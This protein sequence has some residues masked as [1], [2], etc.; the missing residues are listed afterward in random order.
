MLARAGVHGRVAVRRV[1]A[2]TGRA[3]LLASP[4]MDPPRPDL[5]TFIALPALSL[6]DGRNSLDM[7]AGSFCHPFLLAVEHPMHEGNCDRALAH[8]G[9][10]ALDIACPDV[11][12]REYSWQT[13]F[14]KMGRSGNRPMSAGQIPLGQVRP[15]LNES[16]RIKGDAPI[17]PLGTRDGPG[18][19]KDVP[20]VVGLDG[21]SLVIAPAHF[22]EMTTTLKGDDFSIGSN[23]DGRILF[24]AA[25]QIPG[26]ALR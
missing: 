2:A 24:D 12:H 21:A 9:R 18:H 14:E 17:K 25:N 1:V 20:Y 3:A 7:S 22:L 5:H 10:H 11:T 15:S 6:F 13:C 8:C 26:H 4:Q 16:F 19:E 23:V